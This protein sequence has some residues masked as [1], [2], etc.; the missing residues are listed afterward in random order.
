MYE[1][2]KFNKIE[3][4]VLYSIA[5][6]RK[7]ISYEE[8]YKSLTEIN[9]KVINSA[10]RKLKDMKLI[11]KGRGK[12]LIVLSTKK[13]ALNKIKIMLGIHWESNWEEDWKNVREI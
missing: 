12:T 9:E 8:L 5:Q 7:P 1:G 4:I 3:E 2:Y 13:Y 11:I 6:N 10:L